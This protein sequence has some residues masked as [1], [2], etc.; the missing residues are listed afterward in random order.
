VIGLHKTSEGAIEQSVLG[1]M[2][3][4][5]THRFQQLAL[6]VLSKAKTFHYLMAS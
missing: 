2:H 4:G 1:E 3:A 5:K 6:K